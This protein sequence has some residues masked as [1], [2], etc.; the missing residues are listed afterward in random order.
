[1]KKNQSK[2]KVMRKSS[3]GARVILILVVM[4]AMFLVVT[5]KNIS[6][7]TEMG[8]QSAVVTNGY[9]SLESALIDITSSYKDVNLNAS[10]CTYRTADNTIYMEEM[11]TALDKT[12]VNIEVLDKAVKACN[13]AEITSSYEELRVSLDEYMDDA[14]NFYEKLA[15]GSSDLATKV[16]ALSAKKVTCDLKMEAL[17]EVVNSKAAKAAGIVEDKISSTKSTGYLYVLVFVVVAVVAIFIVMKTIAGP[18]KSSGKRINNIVDKI[19]KGEGDLTE[20]VPVS[21]N[22]EIGQMASGVNNF[23]EQLQDIMKKLKDE[24]SNIQN[25]ADEITRQVGES[26]TNADS[27]SAAMEQMSASM[28]QV[29]SSLNTIADGTNEILKEAEAM[30]SST[31]EG[32]VLVDEIKDRAQ[33]MHN[34]TIANKDATSARMDAI[35]GLVE[36][37]VEESKSAQQIESLTGEILSIASQTNLLALNASIEAARAGEAGKGF[38]VVADEIRQLADSSRTTANNIQDISVV[39]VSA[40]NKLAG[41]ATELIK[42][43]DDKVM[44]DYDGFV[45]LSEQYEADADTVNNLISEF[46]R[47]T[48]EIKNTIV[49][50]NESI[51]DISAAVDDTANGASSVADNAASLVESISQIQT[52]SA[53][54]Q[55]ISLKL[56]S[57]V[58]RFKNV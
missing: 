32:V 23:I 34:Q 16:A 1:M 2:T 9:L 41:N 48:E 43:I 14:S 58:N 11:K 47:N 13:D 22:D 37:A 50:M 57:E 55:D 10:I 15:R 24:A 8:K 21:S 19:S 31:D 25:T 27:V 35:K 46:S 18:A 56:S 40:V 3:L 42:F 36:G 20:R 29:S 26:N 33:S 4:I 30:V 53:I 38:A 44:K 39:V 49:G 12:F 7:I 54:N 5:T 6:S 51:S 45:S 28:I 17:D 52:Q